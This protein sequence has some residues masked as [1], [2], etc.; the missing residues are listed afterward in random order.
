MIFQMFLQKPLAHWDNIREGIKDRHADLIAMDKIIFLKGQNQK[1]KI[2][3][4][5]TKLKNEP[6]IFNIHEYSLMHLH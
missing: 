2:R 5:V 6:E 4:V 1:V 3:R